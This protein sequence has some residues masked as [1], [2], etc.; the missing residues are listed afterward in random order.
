VKAASDVYSPIAGEVLGGN[1]ALADTP[2][3]IN[4]DPY[5]D[6]WLFK[7]RPANAADVDALLDAVAYAKHLDETAG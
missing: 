1:S 4:A 5:G 6:G 7:L 3:K 2:E